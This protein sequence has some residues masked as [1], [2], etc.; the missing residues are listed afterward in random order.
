M[1][2]D[3]KS[4]RSPL[5]QSLQLPAPAEYIRVGQHECDPPLCHVDVFRVK[6]IGQGVGFA[7]V[8]HAAVGYP[9]GGVVLRDCEK[10][11]A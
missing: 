10:P 7:L 8:I 6:R 1:G 4:T 9:V 3:K 2:I 5:A 11:T